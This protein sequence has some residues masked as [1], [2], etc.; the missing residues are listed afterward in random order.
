MCLCWLWHTSKTNK[1]SGLLSLFWSWISK[2]HVFFS[3]LRFHLHQRF[4]P[5]F[6]YRQKKKNTTSHTFGSKPF[7]SKTIKQRISNLLDLQPPPTPGFHNP[8][9]IQPGK[10]P[11]DPPST[12]IHH[13]VGSGLGFPVRFPAQ[14]EAESSGAAP[15]AW[16]HVER[17]ASNWSRFKMVEVVPCVG[18][19]C[20]CVGKNV[21]WRKHGEKNMGK[22]SWEKKHGTNERTQRTALTVSNPPSWNPCLRGKKSKIPWDEGGSLDRWGQDRSCS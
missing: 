1:T 8:P 15:G 11:P 12:T 21:E 16:S 13:P 10:I 9:P 7:I 18:V 19:V 5:I 4:F 20:F 14:F 17:G 3:Y 22:S 2:Q 6:P